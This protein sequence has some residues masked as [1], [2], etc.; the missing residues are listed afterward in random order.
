MEAITMINFA[1][2]K[3]NF[4]GRLFVILIVAGLA[5][6]AM[7]RGANGTSTKPVY[8]SSV[9]SYVRYATG[10]EIYGSPNTW[11]SSAQRYGYHLSDQP[12]TGGVICFTNGAYETSAAYGFVAVVVYY[13]DDGSYWNIGTR[14]AYPGA[15]DYYNH[16]PAREQ[17]YRVR[18]ADPDVHY[19]YRL[20]MNVRPVGYYYRPEYSGYNIVQREYALAPNAKEVTIYS[21]DRYQKVYVSPGQVVRTLARAEI[22]ETLWVFVKTSYEK[23]KVYAR[24][25]RDG[26][27]Q[28]TRFDANSSEAYQLY[29]ARNYGDTVLDIGYTDYSSIMRNRG[30]VT[31]LIKKGGNPMKL[32]P[33]QTITLQLAGK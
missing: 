26:K 11:Y 13:D 23:D 5:A 10:I 19:I 31:I 22:G 30:E 24:T 17:V 15:S 20:G 9:T 3:V 2:K 33:V 12:V 21:N 8:Q 1:T 14:Y 16:Y 4:F 7:S 28:L 18:K 27:E 25:Y 29:Y 6:T 32:V